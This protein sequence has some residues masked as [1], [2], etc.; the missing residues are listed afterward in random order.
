ML[1]DENKITLLCNGRRRFLG[2]D[3]KGIRLS[4]QTDDFNISEYRAVFSSSY[5]RLQNGIYD[6]WDT[7]VQ[8]C[9]RFFYYGG[10]PLQER[11]RVFCIIAKDDSKNGSKGIT[12][13]W[14]A[15]FYAES[16]DCIHFEIT[17][18]EPVYTRS[19][20]WA[21][22]RMTTQCNLERPSLLFDENGTPTQLFC[23]TG[24]G[25]QPYDFQGITYIVGMNLKRR[26]AE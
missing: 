17:N 24:V 16:D 12:G 13:E 25:S 3:S 7:K 8:D 18:D 11:Q 23:A 10:K 19:L 5:D 21:D 4:V 26:G 6:L 22:G 15:G 9:G 2:C 1:Y 20:C 14:G